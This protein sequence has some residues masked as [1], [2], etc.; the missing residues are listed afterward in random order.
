MTDIVLVA[1]MAGWAAPL[2][3]APDPVFAER[4]MGRR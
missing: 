4:M 3:E 2:S 1:P